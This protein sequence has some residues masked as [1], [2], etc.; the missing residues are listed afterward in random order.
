MKNVDKQWN[1][2]GCNSIDAC[3][4]I[5][6]CRE[7]KNV[8]VAGYKEALKWVLKMRKPYYD[9]DDKKVVATDSDIIYEELGE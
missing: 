8:W 5:G 6:D 4:R 7:C 3:E 2:G 9:I 1:K